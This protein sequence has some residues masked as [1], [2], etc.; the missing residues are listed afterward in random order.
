MAHKKIVFMGD[1]SNLERSSRDNNYPA[2][3]YN[4]EAGFIKLRNFLEGI[5]QILWYAMYTPLHDV[6]GNF[7]FLRDEG[8]T[9]VLCPIVV[10]TSEDTTDAKI[11]EDS[12]ALIEN[13]DMDVFCLGSGDG[14]SKSGNR[15]FQPVLEAAKAKGI[16]VAIVCGSERSLS[17]NIKTL[18]DLDPITRKPM[19]HLFSPTND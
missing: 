7:E 5:G 2:D 15:G 9:I 12:L 19:L 3:K 11:I 4:K 6:Y 14:G 10:A 8:F 1:W 17:A 13:F 16:K 18:A